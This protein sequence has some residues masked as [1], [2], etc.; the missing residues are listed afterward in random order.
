MYPE[1][2][3]RHVTANTGSGSYTAAFPAAN[4]EIC[5][6]PNNIHIMQCIWHLPS[7]K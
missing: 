3:N 1:D 6:Y 4:V 7:S 5:M 2:E